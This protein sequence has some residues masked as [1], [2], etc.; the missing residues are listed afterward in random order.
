MST[1]RLRATQLIG[2]HAT[3]I[4][5]A[6][7]LVGLASLPGS[8]L[9]QSQTGGGVPTVLEIT[10]SA[11]SGGGGRASGGVWVLDATIG[12]VV[13]GNMSGGVFEVKSGYLA[14]DGPMCVRS[15]LNCDGTVDGADLGLLLLN[16]GDCGT[17]L[18][19]CTE[20]GRAHV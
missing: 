5:R 12:Q 13:A 14:P 3:S 8:A 6:C 17:S 2:T 1:I 7:L 10:Q 15:D 20:I 16:W 4:A 9:A 19:R 18:A 11:Q